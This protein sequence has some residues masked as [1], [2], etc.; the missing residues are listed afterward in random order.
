V[1]TEPSRPTDPIPNRKSR[2]ATRN[3]DPVRR[4]T[5]NVAEP[6]RIP[7]RRAA[8]VS[9]PGVPATDVVAVD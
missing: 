9:R 1:P 8:G 5:S 2:F 7:A 4:R 3:S 6:L